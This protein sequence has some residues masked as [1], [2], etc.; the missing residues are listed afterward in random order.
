MQIFFKIKFSKILS[1]ISSECKTVLDPD[2]ARH[3]DGPDLVPYCLQRLSADDTETYLAIFDRI[4][5]QSC[6]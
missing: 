1:G 4:S 3:F 6:S 5:A 2:Q